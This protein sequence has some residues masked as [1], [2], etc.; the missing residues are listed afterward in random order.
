MA[1]RDGDRL[2][3]PRGALG[4][5]ARAAKIAGEELE[6]ESRVTTRSSRRVPV[7]DL[8][9]ELRAHQLPVV[10]LFLDRV[11]CV[12]QMPCGGGKSIAGGA[13]MVC[14]GEPG[15][16][17]VHTTDLVDQWVATF[18]RLHDVAPRILGGRYGWW[19]PLAVGEIAVG[20]IQGIWD[21]PKADA[22]LRSAGAVLTDECHHM[23]AKTWRKTISRCAARYRWGLTATPERADGYGFLLPLLIGPTLHVVTEEE[24]IEAGWLQ[25]PL[26]VPVATGWEPTAKHYPWTATCK[27]CKTQVSCE[28]SALEA[29][30]VEC[31]N[32]ECSATV[33]DE[34]PIR[35]R[36]RHGAALTDLS[37]DA[38]RLSIAKSIALEA[39]ERDRT[40]LV[41]VSRVRA[42]LELVRQLRDVGAPSAAVHGKMGKAER[43]RKIGQFRR[44]NIPILVATQLAD[45]ALD[46]PELD[47]MVLA[48][49][50]RAKGKAKQKVGRSARPGGKRPLVFDLVDG[51]SFYSQWMSRSRGYL[52]A[53]GARGLYSHKP[54]PIEEAFVI[55]S[56]RPVV[57]HNLSGEPCTV[58]SASG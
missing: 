18:E 49:P 33:E 1:E 17:L 50:G 31:P 58:S 44:G 54:V 28:R 15:L 24:L 53:Y 27:E 45:E 30:R 48:S 10:D 56:E 7:E 51:G 52:Q 2:T 21:N 42:A 43:A 19:G 34:H 46:V 9:V 16:V 20:K 12:A 6:F 40:T 47:C 22:V 39:Y 37:L 4:Q 8:G 55:L 29:G 5:L 26:V 35:G 36:L 25:R 57:G 11:Q 38:G 13:A 41:L 3:I 14:S 23:P 32:R